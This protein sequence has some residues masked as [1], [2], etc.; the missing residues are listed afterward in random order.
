ME[1]LSIEKSI[2]N[3]FHS[4][5]SG[6]RKVAEYILNNI[7]QSAFRT[8]EQIGRE[9]NVSQTTVIRLSYAL[10]FNGFSEMQST[11]RKQV[12]SDQEIQSEANDHQFEKTSVFSEVI[13]KDINMLQD[14]NQHLN[15]DNIWKAVD[16]LIGAEQVL[17]V[18]HRTSLPPAL[19]FSSSLSEFRNQVQ[20]SSEIGDAVEKL[21]DIN[22]QS[23]A[24]FIS[25]PRYTRDVIQLAECAKNQGAKI[26][27]A[28]DHVLSPV[29][30]IADLTFTTKTDA[31]SGPNN[32]VPV[33]SL[34]NQIIFGINTKM[35]GEVQS[36]RKRLEQYYSNFN[37]YA[38]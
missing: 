28:T 13:K 15:Q 27:A 22:E 30:C 26:I 19:W 31:E 1:N 29:G 2:K 6:Q 23:V 12:L 4:L 14:L 32:I 37:I 11:I 35:K 3:V 25:Y 20:L 9:I 33:L 24:F 7:N 34:L 17:I 36:R 18:G 38:E 10:G 8:A 21:L 16:W 5:S